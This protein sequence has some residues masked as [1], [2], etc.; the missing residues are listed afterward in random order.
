M[1][2]LQ[3]I[4]CQQKIPFCNESSIHHQLV[5]TS[6]V[7]S[8]SKCSL[9]NPYDIRHVAKCPGTGECARRRGCRRG[10]LAQRFIAFAP[11]AAGAS[12]HC[13]GSKRVDAVATS[14]GRLWPRSAA[15]WT[16]L[17]RQFQ[18]RRWRAHW[19]HPCA[20]CKRRPQGRAVATARFGHVS[21]DQWHCRVAQGV[22][23]MT[24]AIDDT[25]RLKRSLCILCIIK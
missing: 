19:R 23:G 17:A 4:P 13:H 12:G 25:T 14:R 6:L 16:P 3:R 5:S 24:M 20:G 1:Q 10:E 2:S 11:G 8:S 9:A 18:H 22:H 15:E 21:H 7:L